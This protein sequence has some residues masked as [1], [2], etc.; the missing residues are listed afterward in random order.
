MAALRERKREATRLGIER[1]ALALF[2]EHGYDA[3]T[4]DMICDAA[5]VSQRTF[6]NYFGTKEGV[7]L[8]GTPPF[9]DE[10]AIA[11]FVNA[12]DTSVL[13][14]F[15][16]LILTAMTGFERDPELERSRGLV[17]QR[18]PDLALRVLD[19]VRDHEDR[20]VGILLERFSA[21][22][23]TVD[24][25]PDLEDQARMTRRTGDRGTRLQHGPAASQPDRLERCRARGLHGRRADPTRQHGV[26]PASDRSAR[27]WLA[28]VQQD[29]HTRVME[30]AA[31][32]V[33]HADDAPQ[34][35]AADDAQPH[36][37]DGRTLDERSHQPRTADR[38]HDV[39][40]EDGCPRSCRSAT[41]PG[42]RSDP[43]PGD[44]CGS[45]T[46]P[47]TTPTSSPTPT[48]IGAVAVST[49]STTTTAS[50]TTKIT[51]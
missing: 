33:G 24:D 30:D 50:M 14:G 1:A 45:R 5:M 27:G 21:E 4:V 16:G 15:I 29:I 34:H 10:E 8:G 47:T 23:R 46:T 43:S 28:L 40:H 6:F 11:A 36:G 48:R 38:E 41:P 39:G 49:V 31:D 42:W 44:T 22:G 51:R 19:R 7:L 35:D 26:G 2:V 12:K 17:M 18:N 13:E 37:T 25:E 32:P 9:P 20:A 3:V